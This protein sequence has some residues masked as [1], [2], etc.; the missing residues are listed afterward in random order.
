MWLWRMCLRVSTFG[1]SPTHARTHA[2]THTYTVYIYT[3]TYF[4]WFWIWNAV[5]YLKN[6]SLDVIHKD[7]YKMNF[8]SLETHVICLAERSIFSGMWNHFSWY[9][10]S[11]ISIKISRLLLK[12]PNSSDYPIYWKKVLG[13]FISMQ[14]PKKHRN[15]CFRNFR[16]SASQKCREFK[17]KISSLYSDSEDTLWLR[18]IHD[19]RVADGTH[20]TSNY[21][22]LSQLVVKVLQPGFEGL[23]YAG[24]IC[25][26]RAYYG[27]KGDETT[28]TTLHTAQA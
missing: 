14:V 18:Y 15:S 8:V 26:S 28:E 22:P 13:K 24:L 9:L 7:V 11:T 20:Q 12:L 4:I 19:K 10:V 5:H 21:P 27:F 16:S 3:H 23:P 1:V 6:M 17:K 25:K 2:H